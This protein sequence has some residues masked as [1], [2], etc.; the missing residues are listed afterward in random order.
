MV[1]LDKISCEK[2]TIFLGAILQWICE[3]SPVTF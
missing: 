2:V 1:C 3:S